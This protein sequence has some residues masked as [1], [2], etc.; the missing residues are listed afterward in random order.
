MALRTGVIVA[1]KYKLACVLVPKCATTTLIDLFARIHERPMKGKDRHD[2]HFVPYQPPVRAEEPVVIRLDNSDLPRL[3]EELNDYLW[4]TVVRD[5]HERIVSNYADKL[6][7][8]CRRFRRPIYVRAKLVQF[9]R[10]PKAWKDSN[11]VDDFYQSHVAFSEFLES[12][13]KHGID[14][15]P[16][17]RLQISFVQQGKVQYDAVLRLENLRDSLVDFLETRG[18]PQQVVDCARTMRKL[19][20]GRRSGPDV[21]SLTER[22]KVAQ[23]YRPDFEALGYPP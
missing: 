5:P 23:L 15:D 22:P 2:L 21:Y 4:F 19:N 16:H 3:R 7:R 6:N 1:P 9:V 10:G 17:Y 13:M 20:S 8:F 11:S 12:L 18:M 14:W